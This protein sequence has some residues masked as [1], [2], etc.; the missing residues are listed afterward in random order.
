MTRRILLIAR[1]EWLEQLRQPAM[2]TVITALFVAIALL[3]LAALVLLDQVARDPARTVEL[4]RWLPVD[5][6]EPREVLQ[7]LVRGTVSLANWL[8]FTQF[9]GIVA[10]LAGHAVLHDHQSH[11][12]PFLLLAPVRREELLL[13]KVLGALG[14]P[15][16]LYVFVSGGASMAAAALPVTGALDDRLPPDPAWMIAF[17]VGGP[18]WGMV[19][20]SLCAIVSTMARDVRTAQQ[21]V[22]FVMFFATFLCGYLLA[23]LLPEGPIVQLAVAGA[24]LVA[25]WAAITAGSQLISRDLRR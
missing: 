12:L 13:G 2:L 16:M 7:G 23:V 21:V 14:L 8:I 20:A 6:G 5:G 22:W 15:F 1:R 4:A 17:F 18:L 24:A 19:V 25:T 9:L 10:V 11:T 3:V